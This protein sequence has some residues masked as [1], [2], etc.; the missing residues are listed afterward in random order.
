MAIRNA[1][2]LIRGKM[3][4]IVFKVVNGKQVMYQVPDTVKQSR[5]TK[6]CAEM[7]GVCS[8]QTSI[9]MRYLRPWFGGKVDSTQAARLRGACL[10]ILRDNEK[11]GVIPADLSTA[12]M[13]NLKGFEFNIK[14]PFE[15]FFQAPIHIAEESI[16][17]T[18][19]I[20]VY[21]P[22][23]ELCFPKLYE[24]VDVHL[25]VFHFDF[26]TSKPMFTF[27]EHWEI[28]QR[29]TFE[30]AREYTVEART[31]PG[32]TLVM[33]Q[34]AFFRNTSKFGKE[35]LSAEKCFPSQVVYAS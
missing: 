32:I 21:S 11:R 23:Q 34:L 30:E 15:K 31:E 5:L 35:Y 26:N 14:T 25:I 6:K 8:K 27:D 12:D 2:G 7:F 20:P 4:D 28:K 17:L 24:K 9:L 19:R 13:G 33:M 22:A 29:S 3:G 10:T 16:K 1:N 18:I